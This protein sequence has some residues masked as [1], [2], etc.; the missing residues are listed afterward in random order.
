MRVYS[1]T[2]F[3][4]LS[5]RINRAS[6]FNG[7]CAIRYPRGSEKDCGEFDITS[8][9]SVVK[10]NSK[11][12]IVTYGR[13]YSEAYSE[14][15]ENSE[16][17]IIKLN[18]VTNTKLQLII[19]NTLNLVVVLLGLL[20]LLIFASFLCLIFMYNPLLIKFYLFPYPPCGA[21]Y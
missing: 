11:K 14:S 5:Y 12:V 1:P 16:I 9:Y 7:L 2:S 4:E 8:D 10:G 19:L 17:N 15:K 13:L 20:V 21:T 18:N 3:E 6:D